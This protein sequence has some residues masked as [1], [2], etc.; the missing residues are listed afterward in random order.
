M[1]TRGVPKQ[2]EKI[3]PKAGDAIYSWSYSRLK[4]WLKCHRLA[5]FKHVKKLKEP[6][7]A[8]ML[9]G[10]YADHI[11]EVWATDNIEKPL[12]QEIAAEF[13]KRY[14]KD[15]KAMRA[16]QTPAPLEKFPGEFE[17]LRAMA[18]ALHVQEQIALDKKWN[19]MGPRGWFDR[20][21]WLRVKMDCRHGIGEKRQRVIDFKNGKVREEDL[22][23]L[24]LYA[25]V[26]FVLEPNVDEV[27]TELWYL[28]E[29]VILPEEPLTYNRRD[30]PKLRKKWEGKVGPMLLDK[31]FNKNPGRAC[32]WCYFHKDKGGPC[33][34]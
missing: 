2:P 10:Q 4:D 22:E 7:S 32:T 1:A 27:E 5:W 13:A 30:L 6:S 3:E 23:Q 15:L 21:A 31:A 33:D 25:L 14:A 34:A 16:G 28:S 9:E 8:P 17:Q 29:G 11:A 19:D 18:N 12:P 26:T 20:G 24:D